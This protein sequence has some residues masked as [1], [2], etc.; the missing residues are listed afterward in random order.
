MTGPAA[1]GRHVLAIQD[2][3]EVKFP[4]RAGRRRGLGLVGHGNA[5]GVLVHAM[6]AVD[7]DSGACLGLVA[8]EAWNRPGVVTS[9]HGDRPL[10][11]RESRR[12]VE[13]AGKART[14]LA[15]AAMVTVVSDREGDLFPSW[16]TVPGEDFHVL[17]R[18]MVDRPL[19][20][21]AGGTLFAAAADF[22]VAGTRVIRL[23]AR[24]P[25]RAGRAATLEIRFG[26][27]EIRR[28]RNEKDR[29]LARTVRLRLADVREINPPEGVEPLHWRLLTTHEVAAAADAWRV[30]TWYQ[31]RWTIEQLFRVMKSQGLGLEESQ[32]ASAG[33]LVKLA[34]AAAKAACID[35][36]LVQER[37]G[38]HGLPVSTVFPEPEAGTIEALSPT[39]EG[40]VE[41]QKNPHPLQSL[42]HAAWVIA[43][44]GGWNCHGKPPG[45]ITMRRGMERF[46]AIHHGRML[47]MNHGRTLGMNTE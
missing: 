33:R 24:W 25:D 12:W 22:P 32:I 7:A 17:T 18:A 11:E 44:L 9:R 1:A 40:R 15:S 13:T 39:L 47:G 19:A 10:A 4:T 23:P 28:P 20:D 30:V 29:T 16:A 45:P 21:P 8:G 26:A 3:T 38:R 43:R 5:H 14:V 37:E 41:R 6:L 42:A 35:I 34:A 27:V 2:T 31:A 46:H 36:Q